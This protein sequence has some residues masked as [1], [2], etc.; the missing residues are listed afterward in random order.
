[1]KLLVLISRKVCLQNGVKLLR[2][3]I[4]FPGLTYVKSNKNPFFWFCLREAEKLLTDIS[5][6]LFL[7]QYF[8]ELF[9]QSPLDVK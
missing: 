9:H 3:I 5:E 2:K 7:Y 4:D 6:I 8:N 1:M